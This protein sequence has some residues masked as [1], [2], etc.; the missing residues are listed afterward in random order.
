MLEV[1]K[2]ISICTYTQAAFIG[3]RLQLQYPS[4]AMCTYCIYLTFTWKLFYVRHGPQT[5]MSN[6]YLG[7]VAVTVSVVRLPP[8]RDQ[9]PWERVYK[10]TFGLVRCD[11]CELFGMVS[12]LLFDAECSPLPVTR[13]CASGCSS[14]HAQPEIVQDLWGQHSTWQLTQAHAFKRYLP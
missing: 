3:Q 14:P 8:V 12:F 4:V 5:P 1:Y 6:T 9:H 7:A 13:D 10:C 11:R 2:H